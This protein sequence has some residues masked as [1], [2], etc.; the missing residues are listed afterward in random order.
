MSQGMIASWLF[1]RDYDH[2]NQNRKKQNSY[3]APD[4][5]THV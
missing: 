4:C 2:E 5:G 1:H 3:I